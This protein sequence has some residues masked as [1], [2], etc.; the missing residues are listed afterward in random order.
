[1][2]NPQFA[3]T[4]SDETLHALKDD[5]R[6]FGLEGRDKIISD[7]GD[8]GLWFPDSVPEESRHSIAHNTALWAAV[9]GVCSV[10]VELRNKYGFPESETPIQYKPPTWFI[11]RR[12]LP[13]LSEKYWKLVGELLEVESQAASVINEA[14]KSELSQRWEK[15]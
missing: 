4:I 10:V 2:N 6:N 3:A 8:E 1:M 12:Y 13:T 5:V 15:F 14:S 9:S 11:G 7:L